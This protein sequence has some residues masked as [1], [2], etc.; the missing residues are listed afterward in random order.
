MRALA[1]EAAR[2]VRRGLREAR[3]RRGAHPVRTRDHVAPIQQAAPEPEPAASDAELDELRGA[4]VREL[5]ELA[6]R[7]GDDCSGS[8]RRAC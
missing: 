7:D 8:F 5:D 2:T 6:A 3:R 1:S 4:L